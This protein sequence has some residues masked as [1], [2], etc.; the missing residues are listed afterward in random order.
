MAVE[1]AE[2]DPGADE[3]GDGLPA[4][5]PD[6]TDWSW[7]EDLWARRRSDYEARGQTPL[8]LAPPGSRTRGRRPRPGPAPAASNATPRSLLGRS[9]TRC[10]STGTSGP[11]GSRR[12]STEPSPGIAPEL[13]AAQH[14][15]VVRELKAIWATLT[16]SPVYEELR[17]ARILGRE[18]PFVLP[19]DGQIMEGR[20]DVVYERQGRIYVADYKTDQV[21]DGEIPGVMHDYR[22][23]ARIYT[24][25]VRRGLNRDVAAFRLILLRLG[26]GVDVPAEVAGGTP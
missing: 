22:H 1:V 21:T 13:P 18:M 11:H 12:I 19:W 9:P 10:S 7:Y 26:R 2:E 23:Q 6:T 3:H 14:R 25:A 16:D 24:E 15:T 5:P 8:F 17:D 20:I 4:P